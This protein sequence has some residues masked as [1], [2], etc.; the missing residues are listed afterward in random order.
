MEKFVFFD[1]DRVFSK[2]GIISI[3]KA[4]ENGMSVDDVFDWFEKFH[5]RTYFGSHSTKHID[6]QNFELWLCLK[7]DNPKVKGSITEKRL[8]KWKEMSKNI[9]IPESRI[10]KYGKETQSTN[11]RI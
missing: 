9:L 4:F 8:L 10:L 3:Q 1:D 7:E 11:I 6:D 2:I 5:P